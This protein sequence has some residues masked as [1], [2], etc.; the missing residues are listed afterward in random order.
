MNLQPASSC[1]LLASRYLGTFPLVTTILCQHAARD[2][3]ALRPHCFSYMSTVVECVHGS[4][5]VGN[6]STLAEMLQGRQGQ[7]R[8]QLDQVQSFLQVRA[9]ETVVRKDVVA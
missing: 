1:R 8:E 3:S 4:F 9:P 2:V 7:L 6:M 5:M